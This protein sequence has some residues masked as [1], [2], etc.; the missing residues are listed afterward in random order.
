MPVLNYTF[1]VSSDGLKYKEFEYEVSTYDAM[2]VLKEELKKDYP[3][4]DEAQLE[5]VLDSDFDTY[6]EQYEEPLKDHFYES[7]YDDFKEQE[8]FEKDKY[9]FYGVS[10]KDFH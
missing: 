5:Y 2:Q 1:E 7:A 8:L 6:F 4:M 3:E 10:R 9:A